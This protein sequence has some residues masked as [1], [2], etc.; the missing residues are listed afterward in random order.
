MCPA[1]VGSV[2]VTMLETQL[3]VLEQPEM[4]LVT[5]SWLRIAELVRG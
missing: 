4:S 2:F 5:G 1:D 3:G